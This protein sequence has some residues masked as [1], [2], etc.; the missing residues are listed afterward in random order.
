MPLFLFLSCTGS[1]LSSPS[2]EASGD[3]YES[4]PSN[5]NNSPTDPAINRFIVPPE[6]G[7]ING[8]INST[9][10]SFAEAAELLETNSDKLQTSIAQE[11]NC[12]FKL[13]DYKHPLARGSRKSITSQAKK[14]SGSVEFEILISLANAKNIKERIQ[15]TDNCLQAIPTLTLEQNQK[16]KDMK[17]NFF[18]SRVFFTIKDAGKY[19]Q[20]L[21][22]FK[23]QPFKE[24]ANISNPAVQ[25][26]AQDT[27][28]TSKG[29]VT[30]IKRSLSGIELDI[31]FDCSRLIDK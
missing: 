18:F 2:V 12:S 21:L 30:V 17:I 6:L 24:V 19:R 3:W 16:D 22:E 23:S 8:T 7:V 15:Q 10:N 11:N 29:I 14:Y 1:K 13:I 20:K 25:F 4:E 9:A 27:K 31:D 5:N 26:D 28:C